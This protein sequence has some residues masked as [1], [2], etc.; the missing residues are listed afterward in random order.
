MPYDVQ[1]Q[2]VHSLKG[3]E[4][5]KILKY[6]YAIEYDAINPLQLL[7]S[8]ETKLVSNLFTAGQI[9]GTSGYEE[10]AGQGLIAGINA[11]LKL[12]GK[13]P[14]ILK[15][16][17]AYIGVLI[18]D[19]VSKGTKEPYR[20]LTSRA[21]YRLLLRH[22][23]ADLRLRNYG[24]E[25]GL[26]SDDDKLRLDEKIK[27]I[28]CCEKYLGENRIT[29]KDLSDD[30]KNKFGVNL[31]CGCNLHDFLKRPEITIFDL[32]NFEILPFKEVDNE[33]LE[34][35]QFNIKYEGYIK[36]EEEEVLK[37]LKMEKKQIPN[38]IDYDKVRNLASEARDKLKKVRP[39]TM[40]Q[41]SRISGVNPVDISVLA[42]YLKKE[43]SIDE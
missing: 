22:D 31:S 5:A 32:I 12:K 33:V 29:P 2:M 38:D 34:Q 9:N 8:L 10:A 27:N 43:Y 15:R 41:A 19:L 11:G 40:A 39:L 26:I 37:L 23:N 14:L 21:E 24:Y 17:E 36:K 16:N 6:A 13:E 35:V 3:L 7:P 18:D 42:V 1:E 30:F 20:L 25:L 4:N 28:K